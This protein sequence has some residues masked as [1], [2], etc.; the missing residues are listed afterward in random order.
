[1]MYKKIFLASILMSTQFQ[2][3]AFEGSSKIVPRI[4]IGYTETEID[5]QW[6]SGSYGSGFKFEAGVDLNKNVGAH[7]SVDFMEDERN[8]IAVE[9]TLWKLGADVG[10]EF[11]LENGLSLRPYVMAGFA[12][13]D[14]EYCVFNYCEGGLYEG[15][16]YYM[17]LGARLN[18]NQKIY[19]SFEYAYIP[20]ISENQRSVDLSQL[21]FTLGYRF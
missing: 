20:N 16:S 9:G 14:D 12:S 15:S 7:L 11:P 4:G 10:H 18:T 5:S 17:G 6:M 8:G 2:T 21:S 1:M 19:A 13:F 3:F